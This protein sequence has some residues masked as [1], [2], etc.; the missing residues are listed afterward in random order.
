[1]KI[2]NGYTYKLHCLSGV[3]YTTIKYFSEDHASYI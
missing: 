2:E 1:M 3:P